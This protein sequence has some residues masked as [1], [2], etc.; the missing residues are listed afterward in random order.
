MLMFENL[1]NIWGRRSMSEL[2]EFQCGCNIIKDSE[3]KYRMITCLYHSKR[4]E[5]G[6]YQRIIRLD[7]PVMEMMHP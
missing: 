1:N 6:G 2:H 3:W 5:N 4:R 7:K